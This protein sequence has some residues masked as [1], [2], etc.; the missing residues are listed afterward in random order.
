[1][2]LVSLQQAKD[3][4]R[5]DGSDN[6]TVVQ[7]MID[8]ASAAVLAHLKFPADAYQ[9]SSGLIPLD[10]N[11]DPMDIPGDIQMAVIYLTGYFLRDPSGVEGASWD[12]YSLPRPVIALLYPRRKPSYA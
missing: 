11:G 4:L 10:T 6:D 8:F 7:M 5:Y 9:D 1:M 2:G 3:A 12:E